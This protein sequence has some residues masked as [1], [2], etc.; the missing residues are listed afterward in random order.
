[1]NGFSPYLGLKFN[2][3]F[4]MF[5]NLRV[6]EARWNHLIL[7]EWVRLSKHDG[8]VHVLFVETQFAYSG[9]P[10]NGQ[11]RRLKIGLFSPQAF[12]DTLSQLQ[13]VKGGGEL[14]LLLEYK[15]KAFDYVGNVADSAFTAFM[16]QLPPPNG[17]W[18]HDY[19]AADGP[20][21]CKH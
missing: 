4:A 17:H 3:S 16:A 15:G 2:Y 12:H 7:P 21:G 6:D 14:K 1:L 13:Q 20:M 5:S 9:P 8:Y 10:Q 19:L 11:G 18:F